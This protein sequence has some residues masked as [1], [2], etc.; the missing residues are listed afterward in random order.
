MHT[1]PD[2]NRE[3]GKP[4]II[5]F[6]NETKGGVDTFDQMCALY[7]CSRKTNRWPLCVFFG[8]VN[9]A[10]INSWII[11]K[12][13][14][15]MGDGNKMKRRKYM[16]NL[17][18]QLIK[19]SAEVRLNTPKQHRSVKSIIQ[20]VCEI[21][22]SGTSAGTGPSAAEMREPMVRCRKCQSKADKKTRFR[23]HSC[24][25]PVCPSHYYPLCSDCV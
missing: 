4:Q 24:K 9:S 15:G 25:Q 20:Q 6:Y 14:T 16:H 1:Q 8:I 12:A 2:V 10:L 7:S 11:Y 21:N 3:S 17:A 13:N 5:E 23:C 22:P 18:L 19:E